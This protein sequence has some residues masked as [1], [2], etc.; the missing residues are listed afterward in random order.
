[1]PSVRAAGPRPPAE[2]DKRT[3]TEASYSRFRRSA[4]GAQSKQ[5]YRVDSPRV[6][7]YIA[8]EGLPR[9]DR[10]RLNTDKGEVDD[11]L[12]RY[13]S[14]YGLSKGGEMMR[15]FGL[16]LALVVVLG[17]ACAAQTETATIDTYAGWTLVAAPL[18]PLDPLV[19]SVFAGYDTWF[20]AGILRWD[21][22]SQRYV[23]YDAFDVP[24]AFGNILLG[25][26][27]WLSYPEAGTV[28]Y[29]GVA[30]GVPDALGT[31][32]DMWISLPGNQLDGQNA[33]GWHLVGAPFNHDSP[34]DPNFNL[35]GEGIL[36]TDGTEMVIWGDAANV[37]GW[38]EPAM[39]YWN[40]TSQRYEDM[41]YFFNTDDNLRAGKGYWLSTKKD[42]LAMVVLAES[43]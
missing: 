23:M 32:T 14:K 43:P 5:K 3:D 41:G 38:V 37:K 19:D 22:P 15:T 12:D 30:D 34:V 35:N 24:G 10:D 28:S 20:T 33:G 26:G 9:T 27:Y 39:L 21:A 42:N 25:D 6:V 4:C 8:L 40:P 2:N 13:A 11:M 16:A 31:M 18:V 36:F 29:T 17:G 7:C 1:M